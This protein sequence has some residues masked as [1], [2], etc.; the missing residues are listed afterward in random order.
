MRVLPE[1][2]PVDAVISTICHMDENNL[3]TGKLDSNCKGESKVRRIREWLTAQGAEADWDACCA[4]GDSPSDA[5]MLRLT[6]HPVMINPKKKLVAAL[7]N[8]EKRSWR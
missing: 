6:G 1:F 5:P 8:A 4:Y 7:T 2:L 3:Y